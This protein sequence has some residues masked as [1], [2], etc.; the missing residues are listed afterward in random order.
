MLCIMMQNEIPDPRARGL[1]NLREFVELLS[2]FLQA[3]VVVVAR[4]TSCLLLTGMS[5]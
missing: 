4:R 5:R 1:D 3:R 2:C